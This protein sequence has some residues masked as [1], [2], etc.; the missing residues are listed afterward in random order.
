M[1]FHGLF[2]GTNGF[3]CRRQ[4]N[5]HANRINVRLCS[6]EKKCSRFLTFLWAPSQQQANLSGVIFLKPE[7]GSLRWWQLRSG[8]ITCGNEIYWHVVIDYVIT[9]IYYP[10]LMEASN[11]NLYSIPLYNH[12]D[13]TCKF[14]RRKSMSP[15]QLSSFAVWS[16]GR[17]REYPP[18][19]QYT[20][21]N[22]YVL[23]L[24]PPALFVWRLL[25][26]GNISYIWSQCLFLYT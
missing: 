2:N 23:V 8:V 24:L 16:F 12:I 26:Q 17:D 11:Q 1:A 19:L 9:V 15:N 14:L 10:N 6:S 20:C 7:T 4:W 18:L 22:H 3:H 13:T 21:D 25:F 5:G